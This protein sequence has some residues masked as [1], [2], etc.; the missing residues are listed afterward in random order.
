MSA[1][2][3][4]LVSQYYSLADQLSR[5]SVGKFLASV[6]ID[7]H[8][9]P[10]RFGEVIEPWQQEI[11]TP[12]IAAL[13][14]LVGIR[15]YTGPRSFLTVLPRGHDKSSL[16]GRLLAWALCY[17]PRRMEVALCAADRDQAALVTRAMQVEADLNPWYGKKLDFQRNAV[18]GPSGQ[19]DIL[20][21]DAG[22]AFGGRYNLIIIDEV[23]H[24]KND[25][26]W[27]AVVSGR[28]KI[29]GSML[30]VVTN[31]GIKGSWQDELLY[32]QAKKD[33]DE[34]VLFERPGKLA[35]WMTAE[36][37][38]KDRALLPPILA[39][40]VFDN[41]WVDPAEETGYLSY[42]EVQACLTDEVRTVPSGA[43]CVLAVDYGATKDRTAFAVT[44]QDGQE[45]V[46]VPYL[47]T[48]Q[49]SPGRP[50]EIEKVEARIIELVK[51]FSPKKIFVDPHQMEGTI[52]KLVKIY[53]VE[54]VLFRGGA[55]NCDIATNLRKLIINRKILWNPMVGTEFAKELVALVTKITPHGYRFE[56][57]SGRHDD[58]AFAVAVA[59]LES[60]KRPYVKPPISA[61]PEITVRITSPTALFGR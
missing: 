47:E 57:I 13:E 40:R 54:R 34:W 15:E 46:R 30:V 39:R 12:K 29:P 55:F 6:V 28:A 2:P 38:A 52:Q 5:W 1:T 49:G 14:G 36:R 16:E 37:V 25:K 61:A 43:Q 56:N 21:A 35:S 11:V 26:F 24:W 33:P 51:R 45:V 58:Q 3:Q 4:E 8:P 53:P 27:G 19:V 32:Q 17:A 44:Y 41:E 20:P 10:K 48:M 50:V 18:I 59:A 60:V 42:A 7:S 9:N 23:T 31:A 22:S